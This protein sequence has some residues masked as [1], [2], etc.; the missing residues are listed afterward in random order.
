VHL[1]G[2]SPMKTL[3]KSVP[4]VARPRGAAV[5]ASVVRSVMPGSV[6]V[7]ELRYLVPLRHSGSPQWNMD[8][9]DSDVKRPG[10]RHVLSEQRI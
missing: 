5:G 1:S 10:T 7:P 6:I 4:S 2:F 8:A 3:L 9:F